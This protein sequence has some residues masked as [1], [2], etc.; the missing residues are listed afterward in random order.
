MGE[1]GVILIMVVATGTVMLSEMG[2][3]LKLGSAL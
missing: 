2:A 3:A 1:A